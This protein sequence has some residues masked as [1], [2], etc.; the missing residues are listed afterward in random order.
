GAP[1]YP[2]PRASRPQQTHSAQPARLP[3]RVSSSAFLH[4]GGG[5]LKLGANLLRIVAVYLHEL[6]DI[7]LWCLEHLHLPDEGV[8][9]GVDALARLLNI[10]ANSL[11]DELGHEVLQVAAGRLAG[12]DVRHLLADLA[13]LRALGVAGALNLALPLLCERDAE[14]AQGVAISGLHVHM[15]LNQCLPLADQRT[16]LVRCKVHAPEVG[17]AVATLHVLNA[18]AH[19]AESI[20]LVLL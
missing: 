19:L 13:D 16:K 15:R 5:P 3:S 4:W 18:Q 12:D 14:H 1:S 9:E 2:S 6:G 11:R 8:L 7:E 10:L 20:V 17:K